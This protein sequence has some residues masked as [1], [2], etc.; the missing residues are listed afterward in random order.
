M[1]WRYYISRSKLLYLYLHPDHQVSDDSDI[2]G[3]P[4]VDHKSLVRWKQRDIHEKRDAR[5]FKIAQLHAD[6]DC[7]TVLRQ[8][9]IAIEKDVREKGTAY[10]SQL[11]DR[12]RSAPSDERPPQSGPNDPSYDAMILTLLG[13]VWE[14][15]KEEGV[16]R[17]DSGLGERLAKGVGEHVEGLRVEIEKKGKEIE[18]EEKE[19]TKKITSEDIHEGWDSKVSHLRYQS[20]LIEETDESI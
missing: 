20:L 5:N 16:E 11:V 19:K 15:C 4:N 17:D 10:Y 12:L 1:L 3:H 14:Q 8:R 9:L 13:Q 7:N 18:E 2:E 6:V